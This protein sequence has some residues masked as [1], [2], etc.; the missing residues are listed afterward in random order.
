ML[1]YTASTHC[2]T[3]YASLD[4]AIMGQPVQ[5]ALCC[6]RARPQHHISASIHFLCLCC[7]A[8]FAPCSRLPA[9]GQDNKVEH[10]LLLQ[11][12]STVDENGQ[13][14]VKGTKVSR[15]YYADNGPPT[16]LS[17]TGKDVSLSY[18]GFAAMDNVQFVNGNQ[19]GTRMLLQ[20]RPAAVQRYNCCCVRHIC[21][22][23]TLLDFR[24]GGGL[25][26]SGKHLTSMLA[27]A[28]PLGRRPVQVSSCS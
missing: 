5:P 14:V 22:V 15:G 10:N 11:N 24:R 7:T 1:R 16:T 26:G 28:L 3:S 12:I 23:Y 4:C 9:G 8:L 21:C 27:G 18:Q 17:G 20:V 19:L 2:R 13:A 25:Q 6:I